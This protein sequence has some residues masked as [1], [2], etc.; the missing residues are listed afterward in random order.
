METINSKEIALDYAI[1]DI[2]VNG[3]TSRYGYK[4][5]D[6]INRE[7]YMSKETWE[8]FLKKMTKLHRAQ[9]NDADGGE[10]EEKRYGICP[11]KMASYGSSSRMI[12]NY[13]HMVAGFEFEKQLPTRVGHTANLDGYLFKDD[14]DIYVEAKC[15]EIYS[16]HKGSKINNVYKKV[17]DF[18]KERYKDFNYIDT[19]QPCKEGYFK[20]TFKY[21]DKEIAHFDI[22]QLI[23]HFLGIS[24]SILEG[25]QNRSVKFIY[26]IYNPELVKDC[27]CEEYK[28]NVLKT[29]KETT[30]EIESF[31]DM[32]W[33]FDAVMDFQKKNLGLSLDVKPSFEFKLADQ[34]NYKEELGF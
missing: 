24:A 19:K 4:T 17:Y 22:K 25:K 1:R 27:L 16:S 33:L 6:G 34:N 3:D 28:E 13:S 7:N 10:L 23:C 29:Y 14:K 5:K 8:S 18:I 15:R 21:D 2:E 11:P 9:F 30:A 31:G 20:C 32:C 12:Y 26:L